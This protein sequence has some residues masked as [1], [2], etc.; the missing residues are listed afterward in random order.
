[1]NPNRPQTQ[2]PQKNEEWQKKQKPSEQRTDR[3]ASR[4]KVRNDAPSKPGLPEYGD[5]LEHAPTLED[6]SRPAPRTR[7]NSPTNVEQVE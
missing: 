3:E 4:D 7:Q 1:M 6:A 5:N 2:N